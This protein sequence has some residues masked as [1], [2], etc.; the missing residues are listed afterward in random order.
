M[1]INKSLTLGWG[2]LLALAGAASAQV[3]T[4]SVY[5]TVADESGGSIPGVV[6]TLTGEVGTRSTRSDAAGQFRFLGS[7]RGDY[8]LV[9][10][11]PGFARVS[12]TIRVTT[13]ENVDLGL[14]PE[15]GDRRGDGDGHGARPRSSTARSGAPTTTHR[16]RRSCTRCRSAR[17]PWAV[18]R[19]V[20]GVVL[21]P[22]QHRGQ[23]ERTAGRLRR[24]GR[25]RQRH[26]CG[27]LDGRRPSPTWRR[28]RRLAH[29][30]RLRRLRG[31]PRTRRAAT[32]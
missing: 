20:P 15:G 31:D 7:V 32:T 12:R 5:G 24:Q 13:G 8:A 25:Q 11:H 17:D 27:T 4:G 16:H 21:R 2:L 3:A 22:R 1:R 10:A 26:A 23:R 29:L 19:T 28:G 6:V 14:Q 9:L 18:L 30:L